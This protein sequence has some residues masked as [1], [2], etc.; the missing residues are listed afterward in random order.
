MRIEWTHAAA[1][2][3]EIIFD[4]LFE[5]NPAIAADITRQIYQA[6]AELKQFPKTGRPG[7][8]EGTRELVL[9]PLP[10]LVI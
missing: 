6:A 1:T 9:A 8:K 3:L 4:Y 7:R 10:Y 5:Q 2:D